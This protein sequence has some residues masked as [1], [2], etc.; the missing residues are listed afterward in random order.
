MMSAPEPFGG[1]GG[2]MRNFGRMYGTLD[3]DDAGGY[4]VPSKVSLKIVE[5]FYGALYP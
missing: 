3:Y 1:Y 4:M 5:S 2:P